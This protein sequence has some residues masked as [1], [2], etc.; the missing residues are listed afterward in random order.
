MGF[1]GTASKIEEAEP[2]AASPVMM[3]PD[4]KVEPETIESTVEFGSPEVS[5]IEPVEPIVDQPDPITIDVESLNTQFMSIGESLSRFDRAI[6][7]NALRLAANA[8]HRRSWAHRRGQ[9]GDCAN[10]GKHRQAS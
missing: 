7:G 10:G 8:L 1:G 9:T 3:R 5:D 4:A 6:S 2:V